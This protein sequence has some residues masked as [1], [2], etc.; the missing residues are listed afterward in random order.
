MRIVARRIYGAHDIALS[1]KASRQLHRLEQDGR[2]GLPVC[3]AKTQYSFSTNPAL[4][5]APTDHMIPVE[6]LRLMAG[7][8]FVV[9]LCGEIRTMPGLPREPAALRIKLVDGQIEG[10]S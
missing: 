9:A 2:D 5:G 4:L 7:A 1:E 3:F 6:E 10:L 8:G